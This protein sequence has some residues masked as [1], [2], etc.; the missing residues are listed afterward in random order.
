MT[1]VSVIIINYNGRRFLGACLESLRAQDYTDFEIIVVDN[2]STDGCAD[3]LSEHYPEV[4][5]V[6]AQRNLGFAGGNNEGVRHACGEWVVLLNNDTTVQPNWLRELIAPLIRGDAALVGSRVFTNGIDPRYYERGGTISLLGYNI[7]RVFDDPEVLFSANGCAMA[8]RRALF[9][10]PFDEDYF[11][12]SEDVY[13]SLRARFLGLEVKQVPRSVVHHM[14]SAT[15]VKVPI[16]ITTFYQERNRLLNLLLFFDKKLLLKL[17]PLFVADFFA[18]LTMIVVGPLRFN[19]RPRK[20]LIGIL[21]AYLWF[22]VHVRTVL[23]K[24]RGAQRQ[25]HRHDNQVL[26][27]M[28]CKWVNGENFPARLVN[29]LA[30]SYCKLFGIRTF[31]FRKLERL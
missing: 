26:A 19:K 6:R 23:A 12:Y 11:F 5:V 4:K 10:E 13:L 9:P 30:Y 29:A 14:G 31:E 21:H 3:W 15:T 28:S 20:S 27:W 18:R 24:R 16:R 17:V 8:F 22:V 7:M 25:K 2:A 1:A